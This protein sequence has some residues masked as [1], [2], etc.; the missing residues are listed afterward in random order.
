MPSVSL[1]GILT[2]T[3]TKRLSLPTNNTLRTIAWEAPQVMSFSSP[4]HAPLPTL[5]TPRPHRRPTTAALLR[6]GAR[7]SIPPYNS[8]RRTL[9]IPFASRS[10][11][12][13]YKPKLW[14]AAL[15]HQDYTNGACFSLRPSLNVKPGSTP[16]HCTDPSTKLAAEARLLPQQ[17]RRQRSHLSSTSRLLLPKTTDGPP[18]TPS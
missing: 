5:P 17:R 8:Q 7:H 12:L 6:L 10:M 16:K 4:S 2:S 1:M 13:L 18:T 11:E 9:I 14:N 3:R 15:T